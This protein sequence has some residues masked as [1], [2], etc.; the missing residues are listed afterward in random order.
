[1]LRTC[2]TT[3]WWQ[4][5]ERPAACSPDGS[6]RIPPA[7]SVSSRQVRTTA[8][9]ATANSRRG[10]RRRDRPPGQHDEGRRALHPTG[11]CAIGTVVDERGRV[12]GCEQLVVADA[13]I[14]P[15]IPRVNTNL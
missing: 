15:T 1:M 3:W 5:A 11:T 10:W 9:T 12:Y 8:R 14:M 4:A 6:A 2:T 7:R 13:S